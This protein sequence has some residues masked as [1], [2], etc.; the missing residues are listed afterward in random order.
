MMRGNLVIAFVSAAGCG[1]VESMTSDASVPVDAPALIDAAIDAVTCQ[2]QVLLSGG[3]DVAAQGWTVVMQPPAQLSNGA[4]YVRLTTTTTVGASSGGQLLLN[5]P[6]AVDTGKPFKL[7]IVMLVESVNPHNQFD[8]AAAILGSFTPPFGAGSDRGQ[9]IFLDSN[10]VGWADDTQS[11]A[12]PVAN[13]A[14]HTYELSV[15]AG[16]VARLGVDGSAALMR[17]GFAFNGAIALGD[18]T[19]DANVDSTLRIRSVTRLCP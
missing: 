15:D 5:Y 6:G 4:D 19:N 10:S 13:N 2:P 17:T 3:T 14:Y 18:Q 8:S 12:T 11:F 9:M 1:N 16:N 7:Q